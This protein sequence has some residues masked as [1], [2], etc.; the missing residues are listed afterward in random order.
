MRKILLILFMV[1][2]FIHC[3]AQPSYN[4][5]DSPCTFTN[6]IARGA[7]PWVFEKDG[8]YYFSES[9]GGG[10]HISSSE[11]MTEIKSNSR[12]VW[13]QPATGWN[14]SNLWAPELHF[15]QGRWYIY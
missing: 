15:I 1:Q 2:F 13:K 12:Q 7:D 9:G 6:P 3:K 10:I 8:I 5:V 4:D 11:I 14:A